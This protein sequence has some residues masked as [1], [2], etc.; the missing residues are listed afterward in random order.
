MS[1]LG[2]T[3]RAARVKAGMT[4]KALGK[5]CGVAE[6]FI[7]EV[8]QGTK[9]VSDEQAQRILKV[10]GVKN[11]ISTELEVA[12]EPDVPL[13]PRPRPY[14]IPV[15]KPEE[16]VTKEEQEATQA[17]ADAWLDA[18]G[19]V[20]KRV[21]IMDKDGVVIDH[22]L[23]PVIGGKI[24]GG[25]PD[26]VLFFRMEDNSMRGFRVFAG[27]LLLTVP[28]AVP[29]DDAIM[30]LQMDGRRVVRKIK[31]QDG[32]KLLLQSYEYEFEG[33]VVALKD[34]LVLGRCVRLERAL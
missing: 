1:R 24:E 3:I 30:L 8:E 15:K 10:L 31:K 7:N 4:A 5:K 27:D 26:K 32:G 19:G 28:A 25:H 2:D 6:S 21:P 11:P 29:V 34:A 14:V 13:R 16:K 12:A 18:L 33:Q 17:S 23:M 22:R 9:I 20:V